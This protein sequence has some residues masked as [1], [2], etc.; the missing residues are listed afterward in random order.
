MLGPSDRVCP[1]RKIGVRGGER[2]WA[3]RK[4]ENVLTNVRREGGAQEGALEALVGN[5]CHK[6]R[7]D[8]QVNLALELRQGTKEG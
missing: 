5:V 8:S 2:D 1:K 4:G 6:G 3:R 7:G